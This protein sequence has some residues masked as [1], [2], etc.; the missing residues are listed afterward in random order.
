MRKFVRLFF[1]LAAAAALAGCSDA[2]VANR[3]NQQT[4]S[5]PPAPWENNPINMPQQTQGGR[6][7]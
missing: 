4:P 5:V 2:W 6:I 1:I 3:D 7:Y